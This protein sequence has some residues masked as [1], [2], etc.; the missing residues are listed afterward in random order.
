MSQIGHPISSVGIVLPVHDEEELLTGALEALE[1]AIAAIPT[2]VSCQAAVVLDHCG[3]A[4]STIARCWAARTGAYVVGGG[5]GNVGRARRAGCERLLAW[6]GDRGPSQL[7][8]ATT[9]ADSR[10]PEDWVS[11]QLEAAVS[12]ADLWAGRVR[13]A[14]EVGPALLWTERYATERDPVHGANLGFRATLYTRLG[15]FRRLS[16]GEDRDLRRRAAAAGFRIVYDSRATVTTSSRREGRAPQG[17]AS[18]LDTLARGELEA[19]A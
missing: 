18:V 13:L 16:S 1:Q 9:D 14:D 7:W 10:V 17:F 6:G 8:F 15:G 12:G 5:Y 19:T 11:V 2:S 4:S 3:D